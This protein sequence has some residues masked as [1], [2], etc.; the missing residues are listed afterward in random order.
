[1][2]LQPTRHSLRGFVSTERCGS[3]DTTTHMNDRELSRQ[4]AG[5]ANIV[6]ETA[7]LSFNMMYVRD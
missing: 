5:L 4:L 7:A 2:A 6:A 3:P 1:M